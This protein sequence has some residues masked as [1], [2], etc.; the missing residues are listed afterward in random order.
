ME[1]SDLIKLVNSLIA[2]PKENE[3]V[4]FKH[5]FHSAEEIGE[6]IS[7][8][9][10]SA[11]IRN[12]AYG[13]L[14]F[15]V[16]DTTHSVIGTTFHAK[17]HKVGNEELELWLLNRTNPR[18]D[19]EIFELDYTENKHVSLYRIP[20]ATNKPVTFFEYCIRKSWL[21]HKEIDELPR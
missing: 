12:K 18:I 7:A 9:S 1:S 19:F 10:N 14:L 6:R 21:S 8:L 17:A 13:Y 11:C 15:G 2:L 4:E 20:A 5:N 3:W 16:D